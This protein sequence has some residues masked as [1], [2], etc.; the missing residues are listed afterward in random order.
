M[1]TISRRLSFLAACLLMGLSSLGAGGDGLVSSDAS[2]LRDDP[3][4]SW[5]DGPS[6]AAIVGFV[7]RVTKDGGPDFVPI[8]ERIATF[9]NDGTLWSEQPYYVQVAFALD[10]IRT[11]AG[12]HPEWKDKQPFKAA[13]E[14]DLKTILAG[15]PRDRLELIAASHA[16]MTTD[17]FERIVEDWLAK[18]RHPRFGRPYT[19]LVYQPMLEL[20]AY[21]RANGFKTYI[22]SG[23]G[24]EFM[25]PWAEKVYGIPPEQVLGS[26]IKVRYELVDDKPA[27]VRLPEIEFID[28]KAG[29][30]ANI[31]RTIG[32]RPILAFGNSDGDYEMLRW[33]TAGPGPSL[34]L[35][36]HHTDAVR[37]WA[38]DREAAV[39]R[40]AQALDEAPKQG[41]IVVDMKA[42]WKVI[43]PTNLR[44]AKSGS[45]PVSSDAS[46]SLQ[47]K[48]GSKFVVG[49]ALGGRVP[50]D[51]S[52]VERAL[53]V[54]QF[55]SVTPENCMKMQHLQPKEGQFDFEQ[56]D[57]LVAFAQERKMQVCGHTLVW[58]K[59]ERTPSWMFLDGDKPASRELVL[60]R[61]RT[62]IKT[63]VGRYR[64]KVASWDVVN[65]V[66]DDGEPYL[67]ESSW[68]KLAGPEF[69]AR[70]FEWAHEADPDALLVYND[71]NVELPKKRE[72]LLRLLGEL[73]DKNVPLHAVGI[74]GH[75][76]VDRIPLKDID[77]LLASMKA[78]GLKVM[79]S[80]LDLGLVPRGPWYAEGGKNREQVARTNPLA[81]GVPPELV[82]RQARQYAE[83]FRLFR[84]RSDAIA[85]VTFWDLHDGRSWLNNFPWRHAE[86]PLL[87]D[88]QAKPKQAFHAV[89]GID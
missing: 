61:M 42:E 55:G 45:G 87:F 28:D 52:P 2:K 84:D 75:W 44:E 68:Q 74:Q 51:Y 12:Q 82:E 30:P 59:D 11:L 83:L 60:D 63:V 53:I 35:I 80:E 15:T 5:N 62:H 39:G 19:D 78:M 79:V 64:G 34:G 3:L 67:R 7:A 85:R 58:A 1:K 71:Y 37:E 33:T 4:P 48:F 72:K 81:E 89:L 66:L 9:D 10:R 17:E 65:E 24:V 57:A 31:H 20:L 25:R 43:F 18:A 49:V 46:R 54:D 13:I 21:L 8:P 16:G 23:G 22:V 70:A 86:H 76:E 6:K 26:S 50:D 69:V 40:L 88:R 27:L 29:K 14:G 38:Y 77:A 32:R 47:A 56:A 73:R 36:V 41:W